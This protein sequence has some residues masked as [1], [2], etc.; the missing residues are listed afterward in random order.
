[1][2]DTTWQTYDA[3]IHSNFNESHQIEYYKSN[4]RGGYG[5]YLLAN[6]GILKND[7]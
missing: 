5:H 6:R 3:W 2:F 1:M 7:I 4:K